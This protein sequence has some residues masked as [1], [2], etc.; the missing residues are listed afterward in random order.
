MFFDVFSRTL[1]MMLF[2]RLNSSLENQI[3][4]YI[5]IINNQ[6]IGHQK[7]QVEIGNFRFRHLYTYVLLY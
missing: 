7:R 4:G 5:I 1:K 3:E 6:N 2:S